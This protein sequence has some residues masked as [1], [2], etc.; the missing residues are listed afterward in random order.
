MEQN[1]DN[2]KKTE[3]RR[4]KGKASCT[5]HLARKPGESDLS[6]EIRLALLKYPDYRK[7][8]AKNCLAVFTYVKDDQLPKAECWIRGS[9]YNR[10]VK[11][12]FGR[13]LHPFHRIFIVPT[14]PVT[15]C[16][17]AYDC[18]WIAHS[19]KE[20]V[21]IVSYLLTHGSSFVPSLPSC[22]ALT[23]PTA[24]NDDDPLCLNLEDEGSPEC[25]FGFSEETE[26]EE[27]P[28]ATG[29]CIFF[30][31]NQYV[32]GKLGSF[33]PAVA[34]GQDEVHITCVDVEDLPSE[35][36]TEYDSKK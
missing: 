22:D 31:G 35:L 21:E 30:S 8:F 16:V 25:K 19:E 17:G 26:T 1:K 9:G 24:R 28:E 34:D 23:L 13:P 33:V 36:K 20:A 3:G 2:K 18:D 11:D 12:G 29:A 14:P 10:R 7:T 5:P 4:G 27:S 32:L 6:F 15:P